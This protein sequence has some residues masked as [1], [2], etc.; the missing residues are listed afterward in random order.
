MKSRGRDIR[1]L[2]DASLAAIGPATATR[3]A[4]YALLVKAL[5][6]EYRAER[7]VAAIGIKRIRG[8]RF[9]IPRAQVAREALPEI[10]REYGAQ[11]VVVAPAYRTVKPRKAQV[12]R[13]RKLLAAGAID[14]VAFTSS[15]TVANFCELTG[16]SGKGIKAAAIGPI[17]AATAEER[18]FQIVVKPREYTIEGMV[19]V[20]RKYWNTG[21]DSM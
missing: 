8:K 13:M 4:D 15:S 21:T 14:L 6:D 1:T 18:G 7:I 17:T 10:L 12:A 11:E 19:E 3:L 9:L 2:G 20:I 16:M 5:P